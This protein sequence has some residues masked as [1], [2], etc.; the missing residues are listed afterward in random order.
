MIIEEINDGLVRRYSDKFVKILNTTTMQEY[1]EAID[2]INEE[3]IRRGLEPY[4][5]IETDNEIDKEEQP[6]NSEV[7]TSADIE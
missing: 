3:R 5:Y 7:G 2:L 6:N 4:N 1:D